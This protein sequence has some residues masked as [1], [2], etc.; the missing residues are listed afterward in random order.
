[1]KSDE[2]IEK[3]PASQA[4]LKKPDPLRNPAFVWTATFAAGRQNPSGKRRER[5]SAS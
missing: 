3:I 4:A 1:M 2:N 5:Q